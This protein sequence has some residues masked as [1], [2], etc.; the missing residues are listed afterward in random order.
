MEDR[1]IQIEKAAMKCA[2]EFGLA[3]LRISHISK[4]AGVAP[5]SIYNYFSGKEE[6]LQASFE[7][8]DRQ[9]AEIFD[10]IE[11]QPEQIAGQ[12]ENVVA[13]FWFPY[14]QWLVSHPDETQFYFQFR[15]DPGFVEYNQKRDIAY[16]ASFVSFVGLFKTIYP[17]LKEIDE[18][19]LWLHIL[20]TTILFAKYVIDGVLKNDEMTEKTI[21]QL[22]LGGL[23][24][25]IS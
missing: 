10:E 12:P 17:K 23:Y 25:L 2:K 19:I 14:F 9:I 13:Q 8:V 15:L 16:F 6:L 22:L 7:Y 11:V 24:S 3:G 18:N 20:T 5:G 4:E 1:K 21:F